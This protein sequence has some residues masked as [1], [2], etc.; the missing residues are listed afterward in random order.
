M[1]SQGD[2]ALHLRADFALGLLRL[3]VFRDRPGVTPECA[4]GIEQT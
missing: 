1:N 4:G 3:R 2:G